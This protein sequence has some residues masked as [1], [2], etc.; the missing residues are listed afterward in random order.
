MGLN[1]RKS[2]SLGKGLKLNLS[3]SGP[4]VSFGKSGFRQ[5]VNLKGQAR[6]TV[7]IPGT[8]I[9]YTKNTN[10]KNLVG[11]LTGKG[12]D[13]K[14]KKAAGKAAAADS[15]AAK[16]AKEPKAAKAAA[17]AA[18]ADA[19]GAVQ[20]LHRGQQGERAAEPAVH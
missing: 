2:I 10:V 17:A 5:S 7:G 13:A 8:G 19:G 20:R 9:Y 14:G 18:P 15:K 3:K 11:G 12:T 1:F 6:T 16:P 4:S